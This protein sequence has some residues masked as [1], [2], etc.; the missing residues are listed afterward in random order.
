MRVHCW[1]RCP[2]MTPLNPANPVELILPPGP[3]LIL[4]MPGTG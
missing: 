1:G 4:L 3:Q 2:I